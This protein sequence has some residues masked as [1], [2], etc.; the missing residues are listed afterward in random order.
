MV[1][2]YILAGRVYFLKSKLFEEWGIRVL[3]T[4]DMLGHFSK[5]ANE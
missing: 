2:K 1:F 5:A 4:K 3:G